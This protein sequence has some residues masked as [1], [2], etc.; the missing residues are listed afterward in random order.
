MVFLLNIKYDKLDIE[1][2]E[3]GAS[4]KG[5]PLRLAQKTANKIILQVINNSQP[6]S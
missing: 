4:R 3:M 6:K 5:N 2:V 1:P